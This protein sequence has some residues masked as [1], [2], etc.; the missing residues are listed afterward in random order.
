MPAGFHVV[1]LIRKNCLKPFPGFRPISQEQV[2]FPQNHPCATS[3]PPVRFPVITMGL[4]QVALEMVNPA[5]EFVALRAIG[6]F[7]PKFLSFRAGS[8]EIILESLSPAQAI[9]RSD[10]RR[11]APERIPELLLGPREQAALQIQIPQIGVGNR[12]RGG[13]R[14]GFPILTLG[15]LKVIRHLGQ[16]P[17]VVGG[18]DV[19]RI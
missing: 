6:R 19:L 15:L 5:L 13:G 10:E 9:A 2:N 17:Q 3:I 4:V 11:F 1:R 14:E 12:G 7:F 8:R 16:Y 18:D